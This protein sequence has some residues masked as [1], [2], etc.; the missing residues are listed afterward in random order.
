[1]ISGQNTFKDFTEIFFNKATMLYA[2]MFPD[3]TRTKQRL[4]TRGVR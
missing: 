4:R 3:K 1:M 2:T